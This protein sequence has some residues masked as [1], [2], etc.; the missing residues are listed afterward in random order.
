MKNI[1]ELASKWYVNLPLCTLVA[2][3]S[4]QCN[5]SVEQPRVYSGEDLYRGIFLMQG[6]VAD[7]ISIFKKIK[8]E[9]PFEKDAVAMEEFNNIVDEVILILKND[10]P[11][12]FEKFKSQIQS[13]D[14]LQV[15]EVL[16]QGAEMLHYGLLKSP[17]VSAYYQQ[18]LNLS[19]EIDVE[20]LIDAEGKLNHEKMN[21]IDALI[22]KKIEQ[23]SV[24]R[25]QAC[26]LVAVC[27]AW[28]Y[29]AVV[30]G[31][32]VGVSVAAVVA[33]AVYAG[34]WL[35]TAATTWTVKL[36]GHDS[37]NF[38]DFHQEMLIDEITWLFRFE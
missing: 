13:G 7:Q 31:I 8:T 28:I 22:K 4:V 1:R 12:F 10:N 37:V 35:W 23:Q 25:A 3:I 33:V 26:S 32:A 36:I 11:G 21:E 30:H 16:D 29:L 17:T 38:L 27:V 19:R 34:A 24:A 18:A 6:E 14:H 5:S 20:G 2:V 15:K 9:F